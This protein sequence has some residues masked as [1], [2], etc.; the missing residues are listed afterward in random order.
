MHKGY[1][2][3]F[4]YQLATKL[5]LDGM[6]YEYEKDVLKYHV[7]ASDHKYT[8]DFKVLGTKDTFYIEV[9]GIFD[10][11]DRKKHLLLKKQ[12]APEIRFV[13]YNAKKTIYKGSKT[14]Y[15]DWCDKNGFAWAHRII[16]EEWLR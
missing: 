13:F 16:P 11:E 9:K 12:G 14:T 2:S 4:E 15:G 8:P 1:R 5:E 3:K 7:P 6:E 10:K